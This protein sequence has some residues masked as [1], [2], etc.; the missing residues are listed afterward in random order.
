M[1]NR[2]LNQKDINEFFKLMCFG[3]MGN[4]TAFGV[5]NRDYLFK[6]GGAF[7]GGLFNQDKLTK[8]NFVVGHN[9][10]ST[11]FGEGL[12]AN[13]G[14]HSFPEQHNLN[15]H[16]FKLGNLVLVHNGIIN[17]A[18]KLKA[19]YMIKTEIKT[20]SYMILCLINYYFKK[21][22]GSR[23]Y[24]ITEA[25]KRTTPELDGSYCV[26]LLDCKGK[27]LFIFKNYQTNF[28]F[29]KYDDKILGGSTDWENLEYLY[30]KYD[31]KDELRVDDRI[32]YLITGDSKNP[33]KKMGGFKERAGFFLNLL[34]LVD[35][36]EKGKLGE[37]FE[38]NLGVIPEYYVKKKKIRIW[39]GENFDLLRKIK[40]I[41][42]TCKFKG[43][44]IIINS[45]DLYEVK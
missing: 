26:I 35:E 40:K 30:F 25:I 1:D 3:S 43:G 15:H 45:D 9:R 21:I 2:K 39:Y 7:N 22:R 4:K 38:R 42:S 33:L 44:W 8:D 23:I 13:K 6:E 19:K 31:K 17:N 14:F 41:T 20:D 29:Y 34:G 16:P 18:N 37:F 12:I 24:R 11:V 36:E 27:N 10:L 32:I 5:F 28:H